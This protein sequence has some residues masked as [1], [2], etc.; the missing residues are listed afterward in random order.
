VNPLKIRFA[1]E[2]TESTELNF[3][4]DL[5]MN[6]EKAVPEGVNFSV[7]SKNATAVAGVE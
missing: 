1:I 7:F 2:R 6:K 3:R 4:K 5:V